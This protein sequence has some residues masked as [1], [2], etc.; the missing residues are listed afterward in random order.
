MGRWATSPEGT[1]IQEPHQTQGADGQNTESTSSQE[2]AGVRTIM[3]DSSTEQPEQRHRG[4]DTN[5][6]TYQIRDATLTVTNKMDRGMLWVIMQSTGGRKS[7]LMQITAA[8]IGAE[9][10]AI[11]AS[12]YHSIGLRVMNKVAA[13]TRA[14]GEVVADKKMQED[15]RDTALRD[16]ARASVRAAHLD[17][18]SHDVMYSYS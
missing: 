10:P 6:D 11:D 9:F 3:H 15:M 13:S 2:R 18:S 4:T 1:A 16:Q 5:P 17:V 12:E 8:R 7:Q 14:L